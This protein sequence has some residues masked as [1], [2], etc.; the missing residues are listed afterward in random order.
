[1]SSAPAGIPEEGWEAPPT[2]GIVAVS[3]TNRATPRCL[4][5]AQVDSPTSPS[6]GQA[7]NYSLLR[8][9]SFLP[10]TQGQR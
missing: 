9:P 4:I 1:M 2:V 7:T 8:H 3:V 5:Y 6:S 10:A